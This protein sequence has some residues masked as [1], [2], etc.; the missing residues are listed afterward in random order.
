[1]IWSNF[2]AKG[3]AKRTSIEEFS[4]ATRATKGNLICKFKE[5]NDYLADMVLLNKNHKE[6]IVN[7]KLSSLKITADSIPVQNRATIGVQT[8]KVTNNNLVNDLI[9]LEN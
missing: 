2:S 1:M 8:I 7:S 9:L 5:E 6:I 4:S 3:Y